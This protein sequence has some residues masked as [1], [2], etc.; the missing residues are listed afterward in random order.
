MKGFYSSPDLVSKRTTLPLVAQCGK[1]LLYKQCL[2]PKMPFYGQGKRKILIVAE[3]PGKNED[4]DG[5]PFTGNSGRMLSD[6]LA[7][8]GVDITKDCWLTNSVRCR[9]P[10]NKLPEKAITYCRPY[11]IQDIKTLNPE[12]IILLGGSAVKSVINWLWKE[13]SKSTISR[14]VGWQIPVQKINT[15]V[16]PTWHPSYLLHNEGKNQV[17]VSMFEDH[18]RAACELEGRPWKKVPDYKSKIKTIFSPQEAS[19]EIQRFIDSN[20]PVAW[21]IETDGL[22]PDHKEREIICCSIS[23]GEKSIAY[24]WHGEAIDATLDLLESNIPKI[25]FNLKFEM[26][27]LL[28]KHGV[29]V[30]NIIHDGMIAAHILDNRRGIC[31]LDFQSFV[32]L[33]ADNH[34]SWIKPY[35]ESDGSNTKNRIKEVPLNKLLEY[36]ALDSLLEYKVAKIQ[37]KQLGCS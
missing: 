29:R 24:P 35:M 28:A 23:D 25:N 19:Q 27:W 26:R 7:K 11:V 36:N 37:M 17:A 22:K 5:R 2:S 33:G 18:L 12:V 13:D 30:K 20:K 32:L 34:K 15:W 10:E 8:A 1:C 9:P 31:S 6:A 14:W 3:A 16:V 4:K 21:D